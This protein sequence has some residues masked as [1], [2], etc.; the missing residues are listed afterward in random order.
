MPMARSEPAYLINER[1]Q[2]GE[3]GVV[4][5]SCS[6]NGVVNMFALLISI[7]HPCC[8]SLCRALQTSERLANSND[9][10][11]QVAQLITRSADPSWDN[12]QSK[13][14]LSHSLRCIWKTL[15][16]E[17]RFADDTDYSAVHTLL[18]KFQF[19]DVAKSKQIPQT[20]AVVEE[21]LRIDEIIRDIISQHFTS[22][23][24]AQIFVP[25]RIGS[26]V[27]QVFVD[28]SCFELLGY[29][30]GKDPDKLRKNKNK[31][32]PTKYKLTD[33]VRNTFQA[34]SARVK[35]QVYNEYCDEYELHTKKH[36]I[37][38]AV[39]KLSAFNSLS[40]DWHSKKT[41]SRHLIKF[42][43]KVHSNAPVLLLHGDKQFIEM[44]AGFIGPAPGPVVMRRLWLLFPIQEIMHGAGRLGEG[45][46]T[47][48][49]PSQ[50]QTH[51]TCTDGMDR[52]TIVKQSELYTKTEDKQRWNVANIVL[53]A[54]E[55]PP[56]HDNYVQRV[57]A[58]GVRVEQMRT[59][60]DSAMF[61]KHK[62]PPFI[63]YFPKAVKGKFLNRGQ[64][65]VCQIYFN[66]RRR[67]AQTSV[68]G[69]EAM[70]RD[71]RL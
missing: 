30:V 31:A 29:F 70:Q 39:I 48:R 5:E 65:H 53:F 32:D 43:R 62:A 46:F 27:L 12:T 21:V 51:I 67:S 10:F 57:A 7:E 36:R 1:K 69:Q 52:H 63:E 40:M 42:K 60:N 66:H 68:V 15:N 33:I 58:Y 54:I 26:P 25:K 59:L 23:V 13:R 22:T 4:Y 3:R 11:T 50:N 45:H 9:L 56:I 28:V 18:D 37:Q 19:D 38:V 61:I 49:E 34:T 44:P 41:R 16:D 14:I 6:L 17:A 24:C 47:W 8:K 20:L 55:L 35:Q 64:L 71:L 2:M